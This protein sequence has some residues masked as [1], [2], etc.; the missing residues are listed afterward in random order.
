MCASEG[1]IISDAEQRLL[2][3]GQLSSRRINVVGAKGNIRHV[4][5][6]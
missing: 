1:G 4:F 5:P 6:V 3:Q 2:H